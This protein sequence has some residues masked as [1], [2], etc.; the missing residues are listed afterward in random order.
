MSASKV[1]I[2]TAVEAE[3]EAVQRGLDHHCGFDVIAGGVGLA[4]A[5]ASTAIALTKDSYTAVVSAGIAGGFRAQTELGS[6]VVASEIWGADLGAETNEG[7]YD[8]EKLN[9]GC[10]RYQCDPLLTD[11]LCTSIAERGLKAQ[12]GAILTTAA[13]TGTAKTAENL[14]VRVPEAKAE[15]MEGFGVA[16]S[17]QKFD[18]PVFEIRSISNFVGPRDRDNWKIKEAL[19][20]LEQASNGLQEVF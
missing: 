17:A 8:L 14:A 19:A 6:I 16:V 12:T 2:V 7:F 13:V 9:L 5:A 11:K 3:H 10:S 4:E 18:V 15:A 1:L 20:V